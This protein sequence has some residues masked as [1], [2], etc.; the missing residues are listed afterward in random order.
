VPNAYGPPIPLQRYLPGAQSAALYA[1]ARI[2]QLTNGQCAQVQLDQTQDTPEVASQ[3][4]ALLAG[5]RQSGTIMHADVGNVQFRCANGWTGLVMAQTIVIQMMN[6]DLVT[7][8][9][10]EL[11][12][13]VSD[14]AQTPNARAAQTRML[15]SFR[16]DPQWVAGQQKVTMRTSQ[17][18]TQTQDEISRMIHESFQR[19]AAS[20]DRIYQNDAEARRGTVTVRDPDGSEHT[21][22]NTNDY[23]WMTRDGT[24]IGTNSP[25]PPTEID[26]T[27]AL[28]I[29]HH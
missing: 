6:S 5:F 16:P 7:W 13:S 2:P 28:E 23:Y 26:I 14:P 18:V 10:D 24:R 11:S 12:A 29:V 15:A 19:R 22:W 9:I 21:I 1:R 4:N 20:Q 27:Q 3:V 25:T 17:I 8:Y